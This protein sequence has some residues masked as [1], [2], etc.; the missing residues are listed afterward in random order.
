MKDVDTVAS[1]HATRSAVHAL[2]TW[3]EDVEIGAMPAAV[4]ERALAVLCDDLAVIVGARDE[5]EVAAFHRNV[6]DRAERRE[7]TVFRGGRPMTDRISAAVAN[8]VAADWLELDEGYR[9]TPCHAGLHVIPA[10]AATAEA[11]DLPLADVLRA[12][13]LGYE[14][15]TRVARCWEPP[16]FNHQ[17]HARYGAVGACAAVALALRASAPLVQSALAA[18][19][20]LT[21]AGPR[22]HLVSGALVRNVWPAQAAW[23]GMMSVEWAECGIGG[24]IDGLHDVYTMLLG[25]AAQP[26]VLTNNLGEAFAIMDGYTK[27][28]AC[29]QHLHSAIEATLA[30]RDEVLRAGGMDAIVDIAVATHP[31]ALAL[32]NA[33]PA[34]TLAAKFSLPH[35]VAA[36]LATGSGGAD[37]FFANTLNAPAI[38]PLRERVHAESYLPLPAPPHDRPARVA[39]RLHDGRVIT[40]ECRSAAGGPDRPFAPDVVFAKARGLTEPVY[41]NF[42]PVF[43]DLRRLDATRLATGWRRIVD[44]LCAH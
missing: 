37:A 3:A 41:P 30:L 10:L 15:V 19:A 34:T 21:T 18:A 14:I 2:T 43:E 42:V 9:I 36:A 38:A 4:L 27:V 33:H 5:P 26:P 7:A 28:F 8:A 6:L 22:S 13:V 12:L 24:S 29:C 20:T 44:E 40:S 16:H 39:I 17:T 25:T 31:A 11:R 35:A 32:V 23:S 1:R